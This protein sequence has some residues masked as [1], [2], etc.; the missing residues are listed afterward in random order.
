[1]KY[2]SLMLSGCSSRNSQVLAGLG[3]S[4]CLK[5]GGDQ[6]SP[7]P[8][9]RR[10]PLNAEPAKKRHSW[11]GDCAAKPAALFLGLRKMSA[12]T[13]KRRWHPGVFPEHAV[14]DPLVIGDA[15]SSRW[16]RPGFQYMTLLTRLSKTFLLMAWMV[17]PTPMVWRPFPE[18]SR[19]IGASPGGL[20]GVAQADDALGLDLRLGERR[21]EHPGQ[22]RDDGDDDN[23]SIRVNPC[24][25][26]NGMRRLH[27]ISV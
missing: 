11:R 24:F 6:E 4:A 5:N 18:I 26:S 1:M 27:G 15:F 19:M 16:D 7:V 10:D 23:S 20:L 22:N 3:Q 14:L 13:C 21:Q 8:S 12:D 2:P 9:G 17:S 25:P